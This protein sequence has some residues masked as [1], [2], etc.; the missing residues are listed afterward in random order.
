M[1]RNDREPLVNIYDSA[2]WSAVMPLSQKSI[3]KGGKSVR[4]PDFMA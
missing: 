3:R 4:F 1:V 2:A